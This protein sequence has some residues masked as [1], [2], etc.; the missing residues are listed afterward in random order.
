M[1]PI[2]EEWD[3]HQGQFKPVAQCCH[4]G[5]RFSFHSTIHRLASFQGFQSLE[6]ERDRKREREI[7]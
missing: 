6:T 4:Q 7:D 5:F 3:K 1:R 2:I